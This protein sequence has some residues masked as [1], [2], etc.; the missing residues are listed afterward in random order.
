MASPKR[1]GPRANRSAGR[2]ALDHLEDER[3]DRV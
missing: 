3:F 1:I 2:D